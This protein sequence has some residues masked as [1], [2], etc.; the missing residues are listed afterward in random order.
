MENRLLENKQLPND[1]N[2][3]AGIL[4][5]ILVGEYDDIFS[6]VKESDFFRNSHKTLFASMKKLYD[7]GIQIDLITVANKLR[8]ENNLERVGGIEVLNNISEIV[9]SGSNVKEYIKIVRKK[10]SLRK[11]ITACNNALETSYNPS[12]EPDK[13]KEGLENILCEIG[14]V[15]ESNNKFISLDDQVISVLTHIDNM[16]QY[17]YK[18]VANTGF[19]KLDDILGGLKGGQLIILAARPAQGKSMLALNIALNV[20]VYKKKVAFFSLEM[21]MNELL[22]R[23][24]SSVT[25]IN[26]RIIGSGRL[27]DSEI[28]RIVSSG[29]SLIEYPIY[30]NCS[31]FQNQRTIDWQ[32]KKLIEKVGD[33]GLIVV[34][35]LQL[36]KAMSD[37]KSKHESIGDITGF[38][39]VLAGTLGIPIILLS[40]LNRGLEGRQAKRPLLS[41]M[42]GSGDIEQ[43]ADKAII[44]HREWTYDNS[45]DPSKA[46]IIVAKN[47]QG[48]IGECTMS[49]EPERSR[50]SDFVEEI[51][52]VEYYNEPEKVEEV[53]EVQSE[54]D[55]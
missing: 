11:I 5:T 51:E 36:M 41:D 18:E 27:D 29:N 1:L 53:K 13:V 45:K 10:S 52:P 37:K 19:S 43:D 20:S 22:I 47:R 34:D 38:F 12:S 42:K 2:A 33:I 35:Y 39:K 49:F 54:I 50:F 55:Y 24:L 17:G 8:A 6:A 3:E 15:R 30:F 4:S 48:C 14:N 16:T 25:G 7:E 46:N 44:I 31:S 9:M 28:S 32:I 26:S 23:L 40:Q 21:D